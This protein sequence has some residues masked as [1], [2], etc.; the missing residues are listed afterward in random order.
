MKK[1]TFPSL[2]NR[3]V[4]FSLA[5]TLPGVF[6][7]RSLAQSAW[8]AKASLPI[9]GN[10]LSAAAINGILYV[11]GGNN[12]SPMASLQAYN[13]TNNTWGSLAAMP[14]PRYQNPGIG[15]ISNKLYFPGGWTISPA[16]PNNNLWVYDPAANLWTSK[17][18]LPL[19]CAGG[20]CGVISN[21]LYVTTPDNGYSGYYSYLHV[22]N[23][24]SDSWS[25][26]ANSPRPHAN[27]AGGVIGNKLYVAGGYD[28]LNNTN[29]LDV[30]DPASN[31]WSTK[32]PMHTSRG[33]PSGAVIDG[34]LYVFGG[35]N[36]AGVYTN[37]V[38]VYDPVSNTWTNETSMPTIRGSSAAGVVNG[39]VYVAGGANSGS[40]A[41]ATVEALIPTRTSINLYAGI[42][43]SGL[44][45][46]TYEID[47]RTS[48]ASGTWSN[49]T[50]LVL[51]N[52][53]ALFIDTN[54]PSYNQRFYRSLFLHY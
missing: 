29:I 19:L 17:A 53:P 40:S 42:W 9:G 23:P 25:A 33:A 12:G 48:L 3:L 41:L 31:T 47:Y 44:A 49:L 20:V 28:G 2:L 1:F 5:V 16:L 8:T 18:S 38:E 45:G 35:V 21:L 39:I 11:A 52:S 10:S 4:L 22:Y 46:A 13:V 32:A 26:L 43:I 34:K 14:G 24:A 27:P 6:L 50:T 36:G 7:D 54:S 15:V 51:S 30:Y 37:S